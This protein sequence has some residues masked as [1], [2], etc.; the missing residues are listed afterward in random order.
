VERASEREA[1]LLVEKIL[2]VQRELKEV[3]ELI[4]EVS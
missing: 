4:K 3:T 1:Q 2:Q